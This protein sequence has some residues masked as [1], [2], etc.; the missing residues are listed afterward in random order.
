MGS[1]P[2]LYNVTK[3]GCSDGLGV[4]PHKRPVDDASL[5]CRLDETFS[6]VWKV[7]YGRKHL[8]D[9]IGGNAVMPGLRRRALVLIEE[10]RKEKRN[11]SESEHEK[12]LGPRE[13]NLML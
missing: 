12:R 4:P 10:K 13:T 5:W 8:E 1:I 3:R 6:V 9:L 11:T 2:G 7:W